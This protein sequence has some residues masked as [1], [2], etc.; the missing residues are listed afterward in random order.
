MLDH[1]YPD[2]V[3]G[4]DND[5]L[6][7]NHMDNET[8]IRLSKY[9]KHWPEPKTKTEFFGFIKDANYEDPD[10]V[11]HLKWRND[12]EMKEKSAADELTKLAELKETR[13]AWFTK[14]EK[15]KRSRTRTP[16]AQA[17]EEDE[18]EANAEKDQG[19]LSPDTE[20]LMR[21]IDVTLETG[22]AAGEKGVQTPPSE[23]R[24][25]ST[26]RKRVQSP[27][28]R[29]LKIKLK[30][31]PPSEPQQPPSPPPQNQPLS[32]PPQQSLPDH[33]PSPPH[34][35]SPQSSPQLH[36]ST[37]IHEQRLITSP[38]ILQTPPTSQPPVQTTPGSYG[39]KDFPP[40]PEN[41]ALEDIGDFNFVTDDVVK[42]LQKK[43]EE[44]LVEKKKLEKRVK[45]VEAENS[46]LLKKVEADQADIDILKVRIA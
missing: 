43:V 26:T 7:L 1:A 18:T 14:E 36:I 11:N 32:P 42:K 37:S 27:A 24:N 33:I 34:Q 17:E 35:P 3:K 38:H 29:K 25:K 45:T 8:L 21:D 5:L 46:S 28:V 19:R 10:L 39:F 9:H 15:K 2:L 23:G 16:K 13:N 41:I 6:V 31:K 12:E 44:V 22:E 30:P 20:Q 40:I 4:E